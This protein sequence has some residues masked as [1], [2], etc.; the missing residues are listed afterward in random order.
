MNEI[1]KLKNQLESVAES[2]A[3]QARHAE[4]AHGE[5]QNL[6]L[7][8]TEALCLVEKLKTQLNDCKESE[9]RALEVVS[10]AQMEL[11]MAKTTE[12]TL[13]YEG[14]KAKEAYKSLV[15]EL[16]QSKTRVNLLEEQVGKL[17]VDL[18]DKNPQTSGDPL[19]NFDTAQENGEIEDS[20]Q[21]KAELNQV[22]LEV[23]QLR[24]AL[25]AAERRF[26]EEFTLSALQISSAYELAERTNSESFI[27]EAELESKLGAAKAEIEDLKANLMAKE[28]KTKLLNISEENEGLNQTIEKNQLSETESNLEMELKK[29]EVDLSN[30]KAS[31]LD[32]ENELQSITEENELL[33]LEIKKREMESNKVNE[34]A[35]ASAEAART[36]ER[37]ALMKLGYLTEEADKSGRKAARVTEQLDAAQAANSE[38]E[39]ELRRLKVQSDQ[40]RKAAEAAAAMLSTGNDGKFMERVGSLDNNY[41]TIGGK[42]SSPLSEDMDGESPKKKNGSMLKKIGFLLKKAQK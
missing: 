23:G 26:Q 27:R 17:H 28:T 11:E 9:A 31:L 13:R 29:F 33:K 15:V 25:D 19:C 35:I 20:Y 34:E 7:Q 1:Q 8:L 21:L 10:K 6:R 18:D 42:L 5:I 41:H 24:S 14:I 22:K 30:L 12:E 38:M 16:E 36:A 39:S 3:A 40:W 4:S 32:K 37:E 2:E